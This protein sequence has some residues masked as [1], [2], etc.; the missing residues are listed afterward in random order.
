MTDGLIRDDFPEQLP[1]GIWAKKLPK[2]VGTVVLKRGFLGDDALTKFEFEL[3]IF[4]PVTLIINFTHREYRVGSHVPEH[5]DA[6]EPIF[7]CTVSFLLRD[8]KQGGRF[9]CDKKLLKFG[10]LS[11]FNGSRHLHSVDPIEEGSRDLLL[12][13]IYFAPWPAPITKWRRRRLSS[14]RD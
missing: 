1:V 12:G 3:A 9:K 7:G 5:R 13:A 11:V 8:A 10:R 6:L 14:V 2:S 4:F